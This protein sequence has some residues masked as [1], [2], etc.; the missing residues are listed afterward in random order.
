MNKLHEVI[1]RRKSFIQVIGIPSSID[2][3]IPFVDKSFGFE[4]AISESIPF[5]TA[6][7]VEA[8]AAEFGVGIVRIMGKNCGIF[9]VNACLS[10]RDVNICVIPEL[11]F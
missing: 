6:A 5:I 4:T 9:A 3:D 11:H 7:N 8:E 10:S 2:N 1:R